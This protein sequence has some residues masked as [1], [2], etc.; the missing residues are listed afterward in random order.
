MSDQA[1]LARYTV[2]L[3]MTLVS[4]YLSIRPALRV[5][6]SWQNNEDPLMSHL[7]IMK[8]FGGFSPSFFREY[9]MICP[10]TEPTSEYDDRVS[11][12]ELYGRTGPHS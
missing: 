4:I 9:H 1:S 10:K 3:S 11:L 2:T 8:M 12:Y 5:L 7:G 6:P